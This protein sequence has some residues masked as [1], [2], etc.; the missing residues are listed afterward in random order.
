MEYNLGKIVSAA[1]VLAV[2]GRDP[3]SD[4]GQGRVRIQCQVV[5]SPDAT[6]RDREVMTQDLRV[7]H[8]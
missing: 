8:W 3:G 6:H 7:V 2:R 5:R 1:A 4:W